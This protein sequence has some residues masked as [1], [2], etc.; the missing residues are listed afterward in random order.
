MNL[1]Y[2]IK[3]E[4][5]KQYCELYF[6]F[7]D[8]SG[9][10]IGVTLTENQPNNQIIKIPN[11]KNVKQKLLD[12]HISNETANNVFSV[13]RNADGNSVT[14]AKTILYAMRHI[15]PHVI[16]EDA[17]ISYM[18]EGQANKFYEGEGENLN[19]ETEDP[20]SINYFIVR[21]M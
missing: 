5:L 6:G 20:T 9:P 16:Y 11:P 7:F 18:A 14:P 12:N 21:S 2:Q 10:G 3:V 17:P 19:D 15:P 13:F 4:E 1:L 8:E